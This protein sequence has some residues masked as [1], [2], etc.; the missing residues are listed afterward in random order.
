MQDRFS[1]ISYNFF[2]ILY[3]VAYI[4]VY[5]LDSNIFKENYLFD[6]SYHFP[7]FKRF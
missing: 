1:V 4:I 5:M 2:L 3:D 6:K 7:I